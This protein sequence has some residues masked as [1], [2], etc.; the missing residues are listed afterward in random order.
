MK[1]LRA[2]VLM[3]E[4]LVPPESLEG[5]TE[6]EILEWQTEFDVVNTLREMGHEVLPLGVC[7][8]LGDLRRAKEDFK[9]CL[10]YTSPSPRD[11]G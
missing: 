2:L 4:T 5:Y 10:L 9:P 1:K 6:T 7:D 8:D 3:H 11:R